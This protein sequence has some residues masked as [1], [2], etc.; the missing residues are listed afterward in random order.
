MG[1]RTLNFL[2]F[3]ISVYIWISSAKISNN[4]VPLELSAS[5][6]SSLVADPPAAVPMEA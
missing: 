1:E 3:F 4:R 5:A 6:P 2:L